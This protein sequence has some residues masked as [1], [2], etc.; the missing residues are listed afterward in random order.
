MKKEF[1]KTIHNV[2]LSI[3]L[4]EGEVNENNIDDYLDSIEDIIYK[5]YN[6]SFERINQEVKMMLSLMK[7][8][9]TQILFLKRH[10]QI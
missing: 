2:S 4:K 8:Q 5:N 9:I 10:F 7:N 1:I 6:S 3:T